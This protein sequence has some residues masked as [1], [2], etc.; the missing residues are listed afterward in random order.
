MGSKERRE[1]R[2]M[3]NGKTR[4]SWKDGQEGRKERKER[5]QG[6]RM[7]LIYTKCGS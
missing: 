7:T 3:R 6:R 5:T 1:G 4:M 2:V